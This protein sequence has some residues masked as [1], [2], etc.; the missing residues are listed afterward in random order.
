MKKKL[1]IEA[2]NKYKEW[3][4]ENDVICLKVKFIEAGYPDRLSILPNGLH[5]WIEF[6]REGEEPEPLQAHR[7]Q[8]MGKRGVLVGWTDDANVAIRFVQAFLEAA[9]LP[10]EGYQA[11]IAAVRWRIIFR[12]WAGEDLNLSRRL[13]DIKEKGISV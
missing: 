7:I 9:R 11:F 2:E 4:K 8:E 12:S 13:Q 3:T 10:A 1:E 6:K 5:V